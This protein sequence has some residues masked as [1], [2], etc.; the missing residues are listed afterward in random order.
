MMYRDDTGRIN[1]AAGT[2][3]DTNFFKPTANIYCDAKQAWVELSPEM[4]AYA[5]QGE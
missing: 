1:I 3:D 4:H 2:L 5:A